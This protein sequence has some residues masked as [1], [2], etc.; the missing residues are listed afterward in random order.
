MN[1]WRQQK[2]RAQTMN[3][4]ET[5]ARTVEEAVEIALR[6]LDVTRNEVE[7]NVVSKGKTGILGIIGNETARVRVKIIDSPT[8]VMEVATEVLNQLIL[9]LGVDV[10]ISIRHV[11][12]EEI[13][14][15][16]F[17]IEGDDSGLLI[18][19]KGE[20]LRSLQF[21]VKSMVS[22]RIGTRINLIIDV[23]GYMERRYSSLT[24]LAHRVAQRV[25]RSKRSV[26]LEPM[27][28]NE[29]RIIHL[30]LSEHSRI[31]T[32]STDTGKNRRVEIRLK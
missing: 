19:R 4:I 2:K 17:D 6:E 12:Q 15:P 13:G 3:E 8:E 26:I 9:K 24:N 22:N 29:R 16:V 30:A 18:G 27:P 28:S 32:E 11:D 21:L 10:T 1:R 31:T 14:G 5:T 25:L 23:E 7:I 20:T